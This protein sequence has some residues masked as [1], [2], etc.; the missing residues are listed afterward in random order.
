MKSCENPDCIESCSL[1]PPEARE[2]DRHT[3]KPAT[4]WQ[5]FCSIP[6]RNRQN[7]LTRTKPKRQ[8]QQEIE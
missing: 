3:F 8:E 5:Q 6:C 2:G 1:C 7:Y 4:R